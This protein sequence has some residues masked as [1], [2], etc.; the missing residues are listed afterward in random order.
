MK[1]IHRDFEQVTTSDIYDLITK[2]RSESHSSI[3]GLCHYIN[4]SR[5]GYYL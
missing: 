5:S 2:Q 3:N 1:K 4:I